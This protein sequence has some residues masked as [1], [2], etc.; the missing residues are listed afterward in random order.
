[1]NI[2]GISDFSIKLYKCN[3]VFMSFRVV[4]VMD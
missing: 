1:M 3:I 4:I 2:S